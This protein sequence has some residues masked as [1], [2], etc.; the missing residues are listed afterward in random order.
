MQSLIVGDNANLESYLERRLPPG[1]GLNFAGVDWIEANKSWNPHV[2][3]WN[4]IAQGLQLTLVFPKIP[5]VWLGPKVVCKQ[6]EPGTPVDNLLAPAKIAVPGPKAAQPASVHK[7]SPPTVGEKK[8]STATRARDVEEREKI[9]IVEEIRA[10]SPLLSSHAGLRYGVPLVD[11]AVLLPKTRLFNG[12]VQLKSGPAEGLTG[13]ADYVP[14]ATDEAEGETF[15]LAWHRLTLGYAFGADWEFFWIKRVEFAP[16]LG[17]W[18]VKAVLPR[19]DE[20]G[21]LGTS[22]FAFRR[23]SLGFE[24]SVGTSFL[25]DSSLRFWHARDAATTF[26]GPKTD[27]GASSQRLGA[28]LFLPSVSFTILDRKL[29]WAALAYVM[30][31][32]MFLTERGSSLSSITKTKGIQDTEGRDEIYYELVYAGAGLTVTF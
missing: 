25:F 27:E 1:K 9:S 18:N 29:T 10:R 20:G 24:V 13:F 30:E 2:T 16:R 15:S 12:F 3:N 19:K 17:L 6:H 14:E 28:D 22:D 7:S 11:N 31:D 21:G 23:Q 26:I 5:K 32:R 8:A 4:P